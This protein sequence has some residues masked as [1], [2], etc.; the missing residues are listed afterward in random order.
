MFSTASQRGS[1]WF[2]VSIAGA[3]SAAV[4]DDLL[5]PE[6]RRRWATRLRARSLAV[7]RLRP[8]P[9]VADH[10]VLG[11]V[12]VGWSAWALHDAG[13][14]R[15]LEALALGERLGA[16]QDLLSLHWDEHETR[17]IARVGAERLAAAQEAASALTHARLMPRALELLR[18]AGTPAP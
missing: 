15:G 14:D 10:P 17:A 4:F 13:D 18:D 3:L 6:W 16:R 8:G 2:Q 7:M 12:L 5:T 11:T 9:G 1:P